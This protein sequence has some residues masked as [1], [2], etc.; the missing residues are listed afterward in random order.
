[1]IAPKRLNFR[2]RLVTS[3]LALTAISIALP[4]LL[5]YRTAKNSLEEHLG[6]ELLGVVNST[7]PMIDGDVLPFIGPNTGGTIR[8][9]EEFDEIRKLLGKVVQSNGLVSKGSPVY[10]LR[11]STNEG[12]M[13]F[14]VM[15]SPDA[16]GHWFVGNRTQAQPH[17]A[18]SLK[19]R[20]AASRV[21]EDQDGLWISASAPVWN[22]KAEV[23][24]ILQA[25]R[26]VNFFY[27]KARE[28][29]ASVATAAL[30][31]LVVAA[32][33]AA[34]LARS[35][36]RPVQHLVTATERLA[37]GELGH[38]V[39]LNRNDELGD[40]GES[41][42]HMARQIAQARQDLLDRQVE[43][44][45]ALEEARL[46]SAAK[47]AFLAN[48]SHEFRTP[49]NAVIGYSELLIETA[50]EDG[51][52]DAVKDLHCIRMSAKHLLEL[53]NSVLDYS[54]I[55]AGKLTVE[56]QDYPI[57]RI[58][59]EVV[60]TMAPL[61]SHGRNEII[62]RNELPGEPAYVDPL[63]FR[64]SLLNLMGNAC[65]FTREGQVSLSVRREPAEG[66]EWIVWRV[67]DTGPGIK[68]E[69]LKRLFQPFS[70]VDSSTT[71]RHDGTGLGLALSAQ[72]C[73]LMS[74]KITVE[75]EPGKG[76][77][78]TIWIPA[79]R[80]ESEVNLTLG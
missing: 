62:V 14:V 40:L 77:E 24:A 22:S 49:L 68:P 27:Q 60:S 39:E 11:P 5:F 65:K 78:F 73:L 64:Q 46:A 12:E 42:N 31:T 8:G 52:T 10:V 21:Y 1:M 32:V 45:R 19:G 29:A 75:S 58:I 16:S 48:M 79:T 80:Q 3:A 54:K 34:L 20:G 18:I 51:W 36:A 41:V 44:T 30:L 7:A 59:D 38:L 50:A 61:A 53:I 47:G 35:L 63:R 66:R 9:Q 26:P 23:V 6:H 71:R 25:D 2:T 56:M 72:L 76:S 67:A 4:A 55:E 17:H 57:D 74:G 13:E 70:Q 69:D 15:T 28:E 37:A 43:L 33:L